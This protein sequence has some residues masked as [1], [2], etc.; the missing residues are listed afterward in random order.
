MSF[1]LTA[2]ISHLFGTNF[3]S[4]PEIIGRRRRREPLALQIPLNFVQQDG[5]CDSKV[6][7]R[8]QDP[9]FHS[10]KYLRDDTELNFTCE[11]LQSAI[12]RP[13]LP[14]TVNPGWC[15]SLCPGPPRDSLQQEL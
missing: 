13:V 14:R 11:I 8:G 9:L 10:W 4:F 1:A 7:D 12:K 15:C 2:A 3:V 5:E 6:L